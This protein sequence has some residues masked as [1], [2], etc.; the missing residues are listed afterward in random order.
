MVVFKI[1]VVTIL[2][3]D[4]GKSVIRI[5]YGIYCGKR[6]IAYVTIPDNIVMN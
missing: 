6:Y 4:G 1:T 5:V 2:L 3:R